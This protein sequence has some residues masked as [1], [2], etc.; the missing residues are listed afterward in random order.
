MAVYSMIVAF[1]H[2][3]VPEWRKTQREN[4]GG[5]AHRSTAMAVPAMYC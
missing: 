5:R 4:R 1:C 2:E 3:R